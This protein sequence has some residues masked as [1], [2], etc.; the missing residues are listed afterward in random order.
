MLPANL[1]TVHCRGH[2]CVVNHLLQDKAG[3][4]A[5]VP[6]ERQTLDFHE[7]CFQV[8]LQSLSCFCFRSL[9]RFCMARV[10]VDMRHSG[11]P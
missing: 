10:E 9:C 3:A 6:A 8:R 2:L 1:A 4:K 7:V 5:L 11:V